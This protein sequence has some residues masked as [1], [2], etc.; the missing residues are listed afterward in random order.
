MEPVSSWMLVRFLS[1]EP[2]Q[3]LL[4]IRFYRHGNSPW[5]CN[6]KKIIGVEHIL[7]KVYP[8]LSLSLSFLIGVL[9]TYNV[10]FSGVQQSESVIHRHMSIIF[11]QI[12][13]YKLLSRFPC[14]I[15]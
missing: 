11:S 14:A 12:G 6:S 15:Q 5:V 8:S 13:Y 9:L 2:R 10:F 3:E 4:C 1:A 7:S